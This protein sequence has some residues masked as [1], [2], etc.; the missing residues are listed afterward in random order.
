MFGFLKNKITPDLSREVMHN[1]AKEMVND[2]YEFHSERNYNRDI[3][4]RDPFCENVWLVAHARLERISNEAYTL[5]QAREAYNDIM[6]LDNFFDNSIWNEVYELNGGF[7][8]MLSRWWEGSPP[9]E[10]RLYS[11]FTQGVLDDQENQSPFELLDVNQLNNHQ[12]SNNTVNTATINIPVAQP[13]VNT[14]YYQGFPIANDAVPVVF[15]EIVGQ[16]QEGNCQ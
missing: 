6:R 14:I 1:K 13:V 3:I 2:Y 16:V 15:A 10:D 8:G 9:E 11:T 12:L 5:E 4:I 7:L